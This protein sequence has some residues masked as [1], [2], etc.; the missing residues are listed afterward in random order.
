M[1]YGKVTFQGCFFH[2]KSNIKSDIDKIIDGIMIKL[3]K[4][5]LLF[6]LY[7]LE[8]FIMDF[9]ATNKLDQEIAKLNGL[10][11]QER[12]DHAKTQNDRDFWVKI[13]D[14]ALQARQKKVIESDFVR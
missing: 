6:Y 8:V 5:N 9:S 11:I 1:K 13:Q 3:N 14:R 12:I 4:E 10:E 7:F 2:L